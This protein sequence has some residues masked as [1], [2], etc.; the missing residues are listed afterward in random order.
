M[1]LEANSG[2]AKLVAASD[3]FVEALRG[4]ASLNQGVARG[5]I[6]AD[7]SLNAANE[8]GLTKVRPFVETEGIE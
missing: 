4:V 1:K 6:G 3:V 7:R 5:A 8:N 2:T